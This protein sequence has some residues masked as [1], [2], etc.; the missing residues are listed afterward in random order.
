[1]IE[2]FS[3]MP[4]NI[5]LGLAHAMSPTNFFFCFLGVLV[6]TFIG[7]L[8]GIGSLAAISLLLPVTFH[9]DASAAI[10]VSLR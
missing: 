10:I 1:M 7:V 5:A 9:L 6:G 2:I 4:D 3:T 8:P